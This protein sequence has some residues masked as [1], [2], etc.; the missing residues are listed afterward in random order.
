[1]TFDI[2]MQMMAGPAALR[3]RQQVDPSCS[4]ARFYRNKMMPIFRNIT[5]RRIVVLDEM[6]FNPA[7]Q[8]CGA[9]ETYLVCLGLKSL[10]SD[11]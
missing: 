1:M 7:I 8:P 5:S 2:S 10:A 11:E 4:R 6:L 9:L 3:R